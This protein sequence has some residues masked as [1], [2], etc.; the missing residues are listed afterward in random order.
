[1]QDFDYNYFKKK[2]VDKTEVL[3]KYTN[4]Y[5]VCIDFMSDV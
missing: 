3:L 4:V 2:Y 5:N 1:M